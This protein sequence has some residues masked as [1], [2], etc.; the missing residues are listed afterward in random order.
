VGVAQDIAKE[1]VAFNNGVE[2]L[3]PPLNIHW[4]TFHM[5]ML[6]IGSN[7]RFIVRGPLS[8]VVLLR[9]A[10]RDSTQGSISAL[11][12][13][14]EHFITRTTTIYLEHL[15]FI[16]HLTSKV[17]EIRFAMALIACWLQAAF[18][19]H[20]APSLGDLRHSNLRLRGGGKAVAAAKGDKASTSKYVRPRTKARAHT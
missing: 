3:Q 14:T 13:G 6:R 7:Q 4:P 15:I 18:R 19:D 9:P 5:L 11:W 20:H 16:I 12:D 8:C 17:S 1:T 10:T 2:L